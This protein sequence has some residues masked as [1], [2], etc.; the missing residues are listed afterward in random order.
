MNDCTGC[1]I[2]MYVYTTVHNVDI[3]MFK[4]TAII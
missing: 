3:R 2:C 1:N 4:L